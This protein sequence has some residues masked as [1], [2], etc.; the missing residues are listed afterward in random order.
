VISLLCTDGSPLALDALRR[1]LE[2]VRGAD[3]VVVATVVDTTDPMDV[4]GAGIAG[5]LISP[6]EAERRDR[7]AVDAGEAL[8]AATVEA[9]GLEGAEA[10]VLAGPVGDALCR[11]AESIGADVLVIGTRGRSGLR[12]AILGSV[13]SH[14]VANAPCP[15]VTVG[16]DSL[17]A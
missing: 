9:L 1:G 13:S 14:V 5:G 2:V 4:M 7:S 17:D 3:R 15:V 12:R 8:I 16:P 6:D 11:F 10:Q